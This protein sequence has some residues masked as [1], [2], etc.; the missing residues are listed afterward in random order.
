[1]SGTWIIPS[2]SVSENDTFSSNWVGIGGYGE[3]SLIQAGTEH[4]CV[5]GQLEYFAWYELLPRTITRIHTLNIYPGDKI[6]TNITLLDYDDNSWLIT[7]EDHTRG[8]LFQKTV[9]YNSSMKCV[10]WIVERPTVEGKISTLADF[11]TTTL[12]NCTATINGVT[13]A[14]ADFL[15]TPVV[16][17][18]SDE[19]DLVS[20]SPLSS[21][22]ASFSV[23]YIKPTDKKPITTQTIAP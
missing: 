2:V 16:M 18:D 12:T 4:Q 23:T 21:D 22:G 8:T 3:T 5:D 17:V 13:G 6:T 1:V 11:G 9:T 15:Y 19:N 10:E 14:I 20:T 7:L